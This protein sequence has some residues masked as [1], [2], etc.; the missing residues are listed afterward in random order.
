VHTRF[1]WG[2]LR[3]RGNLE[4]M[5]VDGRIIL[6]WIFKTLDGP[7]TGLVW[8]GIGRNC[9][10]LFNAAMNLQVPYNAGNFLIG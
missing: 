5:G 7:G 3:E 8:L 1:W 9:G 6:K 10:L 4:D 2:D